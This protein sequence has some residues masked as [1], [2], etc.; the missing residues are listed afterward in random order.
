MADCDVDVIPS[1]TNAR[2]ARAECGVSGWT[3]RNRRW[4]VDAQMDADRH[5][6]RHDPTPQ[7]SGE[8]DR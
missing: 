2:A 7:G 5:R 6:K 1:P 3:G 4:W 8:G